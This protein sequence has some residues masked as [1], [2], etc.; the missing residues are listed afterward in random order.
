MDILK[1]ISKF[2]TGEKQKLLKFERYYKGEHDIKNKKTSSPN[3]P[4]HKLTT[5]FCKI[6]TNTTAGYFMGTNVTYETQD[7]NLK[8][9]IEKITD[10][11]SD[12]TVN[13]NHAL[14]L[15]MFG[16][17]FEIEW[18]DDDKQYR[19]KD[20]SPLEMIPIYDIDIDKT[21]KKVIRFYDI[22]NPE[23]DSTIRYIEVLDDRVI[24]KYKCDSSTLTELE[25]LGA[26]EHHFG[27]CPVIEIIN[28]KYK[29]SD[30]DDVISLQDG[31]NKHQSL[32]LDDFDYLADAYLM[33]E[34][35]DVDMEEAKKM[36]D[37]RIILG[38]GAFLTKSDNGVASENF[39]TRV[40]D[41]IFSTSATVDLQ[42]ESMGNTS[43][44]A[45]I[46]KFQCME[47]RVA[48]TQKMFEDG[49][50]K[51]FDFIV[52]I[53]NLKGGSYE[54][55][56]SY[57]FT[58]NIAKNLKEIAEIIDMLRD[59]LPIETLIRQIPFIKNPEEEYKKLL[60]EKPDFVQF[61]T[62][63]DDDDE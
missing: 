19:Y 46:Y 60:K 24:E 13:M 4:N 38:K 22:E 15:S 25:F 10:F 26:T 33:F 27:R 9:E 36:R 11:N 40:R 53:L 49:L 51:R 6:I 56:I 29:M 47:N 30:F 23:G 52:H 31:Y 18:L 54:N 34:D 41:D 63:I 21:L 28:N 2:E 8:K 20:V 3:K 45:L 58:R 61:N 5:N 32:T 59:I 42:C 44:E 14:N 62:G 48:T 50:N 12:D 57:K 1:I 55:D 17:T 39:K 7:E 43:G 37:N 16:K 35:G